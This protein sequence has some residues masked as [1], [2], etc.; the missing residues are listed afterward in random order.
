M[1]PLFLFVLFV[2]L[3]A[4]AFDYSNGFHDAANSIATV[5]ATRV[6]RPYQA[7]AWAAFFN[8][9]AAF[10]LETGVAA[11]VGKGTIHKEIVDVQIIFSCL[12]GAIGWNVTTWYLG[13]PSS[14][15]HALIGGLVGAAL[16]K[17]GPSGIVASGLAKT[18]MFIVLSP[19]I[20]MLLALTISTGVTWLI[21]GAHQ[22]AGPEV[23]RSKNPL[24]VMASAFSAPGNVRRWSRVLQ[25]FSA[26]FYSF[27]HGMN[28]AQKTMGIIAVLLVSMK[29]S[30]PELQAAPAWLMPPNS[31][32]HMPWVI[33]LS[34][35]AAIALGTLSGG[36]KIVRTMGM[37]ITELDPLR[38]V[39]AETA[40][41]L[42]V[43]GASLAHIPVS[44]THTITGAIVG[45]GA[46]RRMSAVRWGVAR[47]IVWAWILTIPAAATLSAA[48]YLICARLWPVLPAMGQILL[49]VA[50]LALLGYAGLAWFRST[51]NGHAV[52]A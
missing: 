37:R 8:F 20:G 41:A 48:T 27:S 34:A 7:V 24:R 47:T 4:L 46:S 50:V 17:A 30:V 33:V 3:L 45:V 36:W 16:V 5:V 31:L 19:T 44:T 49:V 12:V 1:S 18:S 23:P 15:S 26:G 11:T 51:K 52:H 2:V 14:S 21:H 28:D 32:D 10:S 40:G 43:V 25:L 35:H 39:C 9:V 6:L 42:T 29:S 38:G 13:L 22:F